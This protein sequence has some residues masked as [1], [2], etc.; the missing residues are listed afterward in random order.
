VSIRSPDDPGWLDGDGAQV[1]LSI[2]L[3]LRADNSYMGCSA[4]TDLDWVAE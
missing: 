1:Q 3:D 2:H 4:G